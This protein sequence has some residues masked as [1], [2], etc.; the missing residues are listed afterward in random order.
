VRL[1]DVKTGAQ[2][3]EMGPTPDDLYGVA[4]SRDG[5]SL[6]TSGYAGHITLW[7]LGAG[8]ALA[9]RKLKSFG[10]YCIAFTPDGKSVVTGHD[11]HTCYVN[12]LGAP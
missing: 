2:V 3:K 8:K 7:D 10:A 1:W 6:A 4:F 11:N 5:K 12:A 9:S